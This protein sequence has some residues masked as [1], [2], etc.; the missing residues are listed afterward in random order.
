MFMGITKKSGNK[1]LFQ[2]VPGAFVIPLS[3]LFTSL[4]SITMLWYAANSNQLSLFVIC[5]LVL[6]FICGLIGVASS[7]QQTMCCVELSDSYATCFVPFG[8]RIQILYAESHIGIDY[9]IQNGNKIWWIYLCYGNQTPC[10][11]KNT[12][13]R[14]NTLKCQPGFIRIMYRDEVYEALISMLPEKQKAALETARR[15]SEI[16]K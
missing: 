8:K 15:F 9:H 11:S 7:I 6:Y 14:M 1:K 3:C 4:F 12:V 5:G 10:K 13:H 16:D 2:S